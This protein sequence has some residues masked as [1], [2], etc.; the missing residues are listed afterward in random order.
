MKIIFSFALLTIAAC[1]ASAQFDVLGQSYRQYQLQ[2]PL[3]LQ[4]QVLSP[5][6]EFVRQQYGITASPLLQSVAFQ[7]RNNQVWQQLWL[8]AQ[9]SHYE[10]INIFQV[11]AQ[12]LQLQQFDDL[13]FD[14]N[15]AQAPAQAL[16]ALNL[17]SR[18]G[19][20]PRYYSAPGSITTLGGLL[21]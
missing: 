3:L 15:L 12:Q 19:I 2:S 13:Y 6:N 7:L 5:Y 21:Y 17:P 4:Q 18:Y 10:D 14:R 16:L 9:Q 1:S 20:Y 8:V 11:I